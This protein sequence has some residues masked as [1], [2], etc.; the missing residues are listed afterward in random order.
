MFVH[1]VQME[2]LIIFL[3]SQDEH[4]CKV[5]TTSAT[6]TKP[7]TQTPALPNVEKINHKKCGT[8][9]TDRITGGEVTKVGDFPWMALIRYSSAADKTKLFF[10]CGGSLIT[11]NHV[12]TAAHC[13]SYEGLDL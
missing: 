1:Y 11:K 6:S 3:K 10:A 2:V 5:S 8:M 4:C 7:T 12:L 9:Q 13:I